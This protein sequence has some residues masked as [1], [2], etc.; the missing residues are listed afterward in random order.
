MNK[1]L[2]ILSKQILLVKP[3][4]VSKV[5]FAKT[6]YLTF[7]G[8]VQ[9]NTLVREDMKFIRMPLGPVPDGFMDLFTDEDITLSETLTGLSYNKQVYNLQNKQIEKVPYIDQITKILTGIDSLQTSELVEYTHKEPSW[10]SHANGMTYIIQDEDL[11]IQLP[12]STGITNKDPERDNQRL[13]AYLLDGM[14]KEIVDESTAL[15]YPDFK[16]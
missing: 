14:M 15:E 16:D 8:L 11:A 4:G 5:R 7:K 3:G 13:Q 10:L 12:V 9:M 6:I 2:N 1:L